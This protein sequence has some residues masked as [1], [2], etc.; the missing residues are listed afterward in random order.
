MAAAVGSGVAV[1]SD[2]D[3]VPTLVGLSKFTNSPPELSEM[4][5]WLSA[6]ATS[7]LIGRLK[8]KVVPTEMGLY[9]F[10]PTVTEYGITSVDWS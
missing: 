3:I 2:T 5:F 9:V 10:E 4:A 8:L 7:E 1:D 6:V